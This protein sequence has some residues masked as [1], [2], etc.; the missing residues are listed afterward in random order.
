[1]QAPQKKGGEKLPLG[2]KDML[3][4]IQFHLLSLDPL[5]FLELRMLFITSR[6]SILRA[7]NE[8]F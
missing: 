3:I 8:I 4:K 6:L 2:A 5:Y 7:F 1:M